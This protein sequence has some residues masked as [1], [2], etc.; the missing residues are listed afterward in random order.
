MNVY[1]FSVQTAEP[2]IFDTEGPL[3]SPLEGGDFPHFLCCSAQHPDTIIEI[4]RQQNLIIARLE[5]DTPLFRR[6]A[7]HRQTIDPVLYSNMFRT[8]PL[9]SGNAQY[10]FT[11]VETV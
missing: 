10:G 11:P 1:F 4:C 7:F 8:I 2:P 3:P 6:W 5:E 9:Y